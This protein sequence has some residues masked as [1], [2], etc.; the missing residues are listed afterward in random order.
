MIA[1]KIRLFITA[2]WVTM[3]VF[4]PNVRAQDTSRVPD[5]NQQ[6]PGAVNASVHADVEERAQQPQPLQQSNKRLTTY[7]HW[8]FQSA[9]QPP[10]IR[11][12]LAQATTPALAS[13]ATGKN[14]STF[15]SSPLQFETQAP[16][17]TVWPARA[18]DSATTPAT[19]DN[20]GKPNRQSNLFGR[21]SADRPYDRPTG[22][23]LFETAVPSLSPQPQPPALST[24]FREKQL[25]GT[26][27]SPFA[28][29]FSK[30][31]YS[32][33]AR[34]KAKQDKS[35]RLKSAEKARADAIP[36]SSSNKGKKPGSRLTGKPE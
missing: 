14:L 12:R 33:Q 19:D 21:L 5:R 30:T 10:A 6:D 25:G 3:T 26:S 32:S 22:S 35:L 2:F 23:Q 34:A 28:S 20:S 11:F 36:G 24:T 29:P 1:M 16:A 18:A 13:P 7:S 9:N 31:T 17:S 4:C 15:G 8:G 27:T